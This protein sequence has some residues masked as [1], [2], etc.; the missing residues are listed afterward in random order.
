MGRPAAEGSTYVAPQLAEVRYSHA[1]MIEM[2]A[3]DPTITQRALARFFGMSEPWISTVIRSD[4]FQAALA[5]RRQEVFAPILAPIKDKIEVAAHASL[6]RL[7]ER[8]NSPVA[9]KDE[10]ILQAVK[11]TTEAAGYGARVRDGGNGS[12]IGQVIINLPAKAPSEAAWGARYSP[13]GVS[14][15]VLVQPGTPAPE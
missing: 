11:I 4:A 12:G 6:E 9:M 5:E 3:A 14:D 7:N 8:L 13:G 2:I 10:H 1:A 15:A